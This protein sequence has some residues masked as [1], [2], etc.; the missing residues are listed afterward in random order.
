MESEKKVLTFLTT[1]LWTQAVL[2]CVAFVLLLLANI[3]VFLVVPNEAVMGAVQRIFYFHVGA[4]TNTYIM[5]GVL[6]IA[7]VCFLTFR[8]PV[9]D[10]LAEAAGGVALLL[11]SIVL[12]SGSI[13]G[14]SAWNTWWRWEPRLVSFLVLWL[15][16]FAYVLLRSF[17][18][19]SE[20]QGAFAA[21]LGIVSAVN[22]PLAIFSIKLMSQAEQLHPE[23]VAEQGL[24]DERFVYAL[25]CGIFALGAVSFWLLVVRMTSGLLARMA[26]QVAL[27][28][29]EQQLIRRRA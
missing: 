11:A 6:F 7:S 16:L 10:V 19:R 12:V 25:I 9:W 18:E 17:T 21:I 2:P 20:R 1:S 13:W 8:T 23:V 22:V 4:A 28:L 24:K 27:S 5:I 3:M 29:D 26:N 14:H 15:V